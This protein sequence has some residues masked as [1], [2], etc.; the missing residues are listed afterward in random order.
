MRKHVLIST[1]H[2]SGRPGEI[3]K[4]IKTLCIL[5]VRVRLYY[6]YEC[7]CARVKY[8]TLDQKICHK[9]FGVFVAG[10]G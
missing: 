7:V 10:V 4:T 3:H 8:V 1:G 6:T 9:K 2:R 5:Y